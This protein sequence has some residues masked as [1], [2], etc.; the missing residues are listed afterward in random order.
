MLFQ[1]LDLLAMTAAFA[2]SWLWFVSS[3]QRVRRIRRSETLDAAD[4]NR[5]VVAINRTQ[6][7]NGQAALAA[8]MSALFAALRFGLDALAR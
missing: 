1:V 2:A 6:I 4:L 5:L 7:L 8:T 3:R